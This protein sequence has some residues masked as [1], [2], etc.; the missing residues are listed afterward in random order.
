MRAACLDSTAPVPSEQKAGGLR[1]FAPT[2]PATPH[3][4]RSEVETFWNSFSRGLVITL[5]Q[6]VPAFPLAETSLGPR[7]SGKVRSEPRQAQESKNVP[8]VSFRQAKN[9]PRS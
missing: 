6:S 1:V 9:C 3:P 5:L 4:R 7:S 8:V 2:P